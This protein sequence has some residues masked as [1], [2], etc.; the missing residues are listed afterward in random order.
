L[1][2]GET[3][4]EEYGLECRRGGN[5]DGAQY[6]AV[7]GGLLLP[8]LA[9]LPLPAL[10]RATTP[11]AAP[12]RL[13]WP[14]ARLYLLTNFNPE[15]GDLIHGALRLGSGLHLISLRGVVTGH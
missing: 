3:S 10:L 9:L 2:E 13:L 7:V 6:V 14:A 8:P 12:L 4:N 5:A 15:P 1:A 11:A